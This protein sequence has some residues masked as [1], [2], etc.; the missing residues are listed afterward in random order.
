M[1]GEKE[2]FNIHTSVTIGDETAKIGF[3]LTTVKELTEKKFDE[4]YRFL[5]PSLARFI[6]DKGKMVN[7]GVW[8]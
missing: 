6:R 2:K 8:D 3:D 5:C 4:C 1:S 7:P